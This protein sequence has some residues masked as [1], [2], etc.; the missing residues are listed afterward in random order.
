MNLVKGMVAAGL[1]GA[2]LYGI[3]SFHGSDLRSPRY[4]THPTTRVWTAFRFFRDEEWTEEG[5]EYRR[6]LLRWWL[7]CIGLIVALAELFSN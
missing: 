2:T 6:K 7:V 5:L 4:G 3:K 1:A